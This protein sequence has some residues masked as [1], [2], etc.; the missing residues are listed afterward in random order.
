MMFTV[1]GKE[2]RNW[3]VMKNAFTIKLES[4]FWQ[5]IKNYFR[6]LR[7]Y[8]LKLINFSDH[9]VEMPLSVTRYFHCE[10]QTTQHFQA[11]THTAIS[12]ILIDN[13]TQ[14]N[15]HFKF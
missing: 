9:H 13:L 2:T 6:N 4:K 14:K 11:F 15:S 3:V 10:D 12:E 5:H 1:H 8:Y 7:K